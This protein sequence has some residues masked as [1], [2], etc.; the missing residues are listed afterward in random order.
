MSNRQAFGTWLRDHDQL[1]RP[2]PIGDL[3]RDFKDGASGVRTVQAVINE[4]DRHGAHPL[5]YDALGEA[6]KEWLNS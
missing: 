3:A 6:F 5:A 4:L 1:T 2:G